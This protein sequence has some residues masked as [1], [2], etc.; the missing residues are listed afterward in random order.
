MCWSIRQCPSPISPMSYFQR[1]R[2]ITLCLFRLLIIFLYSILLFR[3][4][5][6]IR[7]LYRRLLYLFWL[8][9]RQRHQLIK[10]RCHFSFRSRLTFTLLCLDLY[11]CFTLLMGLSLFEFVFFACVLITSFIKCHRIGRVGCSL[12]WPMLAKKLHITKLLYLLQILMLLSSHSSNT[13]K[14]TH[15]WL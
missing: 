15:G 10:S 7:G 12:W 13:L 3:M 8:P 9:F 1:R 11:L 5:F 14:T 2:N 6:Y 4:T